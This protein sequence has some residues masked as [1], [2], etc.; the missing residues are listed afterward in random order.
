M[1]D[2]Y[3]FMEPEILSIQRYPKHGYVVRTELVENPDLSGE[4]IKMRNAY[5][6]NG[7]YIGNQ[8]TAEFLCE[9][10]DIRPETIAPDHPICSIGFCEIDQKWYGWSHRAIFGFGIGS[11]VE[12][13]DIAYVPDN[14][15]ELAADYA[16]VCTSVEVVDDETI[17]VFVEIDD[18]EELD[19]IKTGRGGWVAKTLDD[20]RQM[21]IDFAEQVA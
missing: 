21:A 9:I 18:N 8:K 14:V 5:N 17:K 2:L 6:T 15:E 16:K 13:G 11:S 4:P 20:A 19:I 1:N 10:C 3:R 12:R 7:D